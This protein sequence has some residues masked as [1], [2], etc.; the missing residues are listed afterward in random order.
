MVWPCG[1][2]LTEKGQ[3][4]ERN[5]QLAGRLC[6]KNLLP[7]LVAPVLPV[8]DRKQIAAVEHFI[9]TPGIFIQ[10][11]KKVPEECDEGSFFS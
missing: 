2:D 3:K 10:G 7:V 1:C 8:R 11:A 6:C 5:S 9:C 4:E